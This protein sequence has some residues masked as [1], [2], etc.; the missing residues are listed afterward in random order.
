MLKKLSLVIFILSILS[1]GLFAENLELNLKKDSVY[2]QKVVSKSLVSQEFGGQTMDIDMGITGLM[3][4]KVT[5]Y[6]DSVYS[7]EVKYEEL[8]MSMN[9]MGMTQEFSSENNNP[10]DI[11]S[12][13]LKNMK[14]KSFT[15]KMN[16]QGKV[17]E[18]KNIEGLYESMFEG[19]ELSTEEKEQIKVQL[20]TTYGEESL[21]GNIEMASAIFPE[22]K[23]VNKGEKWN[24]NT[25]LSAGFVANLNSTYELKEINKDSYLIVGNGTLVTTNSDTYTETNGY[26]VKYS[27]NGTVL[28]EIKIDKTTGWTTESKITQDFS[29][30]NFIK[31]TPDAIEDMAVPMKIKTDVLI[32]NK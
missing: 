6:K 26:L 23:K 31:L 12:T 4:F 11:F 8:G 22:A 10:E 30:T 9:M 1:F 3:S 16:K 32:T 2:Y 5:D 25:K 13:I 20:M 15:L 14:N 27:I 21:K 18:V 29:G 28:S 7:M 19:I 17:L 24:V